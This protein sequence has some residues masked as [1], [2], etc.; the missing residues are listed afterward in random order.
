MGSG[1][2]N[3]DVKAFDQTPDRSRLE[4]LVLRFEVQAVN[5]SGPMLRNVQLVLSECLVDQ[6]LGREIS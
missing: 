2:L 4:L 3:A 1:S 6:H 5:R